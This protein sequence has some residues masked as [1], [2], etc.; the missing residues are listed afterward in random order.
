MGATDMYFFVSGGS[1]E[2]AYEGLLSRLEA[3]IED[4]TWDDPKDKPGFVRAWK[5]VVEPEDAEILARNILYGNVSD[6][7][8]SKEERVSNMPKFG[9]WY[10]IQCHCEPG[11]LWL[12]FG[13]VNT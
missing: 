12:F 9:P 2:D 13:W 4:K 6:N 10:V 3:E 8:W 7:Q 1:A 11:G 5:A